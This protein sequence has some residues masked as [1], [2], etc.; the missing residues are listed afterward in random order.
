[1]AELLIATHNHGKFLEIKAFLQLHH[2][3]V[4][5]LPLSDLDPNWN[6]TEDGSTFLENA[7][8]KAT[9]TAKKFQRF[10]LAD[11]SGLLVDALGG[12]PGVHSARYADSD[13][14]R[15]EKILQ[16]LQGIDS[17]KRSA[18]FECVMVLANPT[19]QT[20]H[21]TGT[22]HG[23]ILDTPK[24][25][26]GF[27]F[28][29]IFWIPSHQKTLAELEMVEKNRISHRSRALEKISGHLESF[30]RKI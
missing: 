4:T 1:M 22:L 24:G 17:T 8:K 6:V 5:L 9:E 15:I 12:Q 30:L 3:N 20:L 7:T 21:E 23:S 18:R 10:C 2:P 27:G 13:S 19:G 28:D 14:E 11:D 29:P 16:N 26:K 25:N